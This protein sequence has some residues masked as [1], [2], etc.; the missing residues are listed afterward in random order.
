LDSLDGQKKQKAKKEWE[1]VQL[2]SMKTIH[3]N[4]P[5]WGG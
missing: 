1:A 2:F 3:N 5:F 4:F